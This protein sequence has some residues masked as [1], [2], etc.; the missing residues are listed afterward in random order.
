[1]VTSPTTTILLVIHR[2]L[3]SAYHACYVTSCP[4]SADLA[5][6]VTSYYE[7]FE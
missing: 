5:V 3:K 7:R 4:L 1:M 2:F 6:T